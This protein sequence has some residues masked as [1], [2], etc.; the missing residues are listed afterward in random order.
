MI[1]GLH[2]PAVSYF[3]ERLQWFGP[4]LRYG[5]YGS[6]KFRLAVSASYR[7]GSYEQDDSPILAGLGDREDT[8]MAGFG[9]Q[10]ELPRGFDLNF[11]YE[12]DV[13]D[14]IGG[15]I[16]DIGVSRGFQYGIFRFKPSF[17]INWNSREVN[18]YEFGVPESAAIS[19][20]PAYSPGS[21]TS[22]ELGISTF[23][24]LSEDWRLLLNISGE[25]LDDKITASPIVEDDTVTSGF[26]GFAYIF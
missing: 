1:L 9:V 20:R 25:R 4:N 8:F 3:G 13:L 6:G 2:I 26:I 16:A 22:L 10:Y 24:E 19:S 23:I 21:T 17:S 14:R 11:T 5:I 12:H 7:I 18:N 15:G